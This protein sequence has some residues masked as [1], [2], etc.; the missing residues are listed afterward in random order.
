MKVGDMQL[1]EN[2]CCGQRRERRSENRGNGF[3]GS[4][5]GDGAVGDGAVGA[6]A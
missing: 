4:W 5:R 2:G 3:G 1:P 6:V